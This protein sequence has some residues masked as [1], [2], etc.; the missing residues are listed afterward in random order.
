MPAAKNFKSL[1]VQ[2]VFLGKASMIEMYNNRN[3]CV[4][5][6]IFAMLSG[7]EKANHNLVFDKNI[8]IF[9][10]FIVK[11]MQKQRMKAVSIFHLRPMA[12]LSVNHHF[13]PRKMFG[14]IITCLNRNDR[15][16]Q[17]VNE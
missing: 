8:K 10:Y 1:L 17:P 6:G 11:K 13:Y 4:V 2:A 15:I 5:L 9:L 16:I 7:F 3:C 12:A 14:K